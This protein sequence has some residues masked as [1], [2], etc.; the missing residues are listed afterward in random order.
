MSNVAA[1][2]P[3]EKLL[4]QLDGQESMKHGFHE[5]RALDPS[6]TLLALGAMAAKAAAVGGGLAAGA[7]VAKEMIGANK[8]NNGRRFSG[9]T[10]ELLIS[11]LRARRADS[12][13]TV[14]SLALDKLGNEPGVED[15]L[16][17]RREIL[18]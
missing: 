7:H 15:L 5:V 16:K 6:I 17:F 18:Q 9:G 1:N 8:N 12:S 11:K 10:D 14:Q 2:T 3:I 13:S 4:I